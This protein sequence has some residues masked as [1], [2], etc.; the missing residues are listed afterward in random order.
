M[1]SYTLKSKSKP[2]TRQ[3][4]KRNM[5]SLV[6]FFGG[7]C[8]A[9]AYYSLMLT[10]CCLPAGAIIGLTESL[11]EIIRDARKYGCHDRGVVNDFRRWL[12]FLLVVIVWFAIMGASI[13]F[14]VIGPDWMDTHGYKPSPMFII[15]GFIFGLWLGGWLIQKLDKG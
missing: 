10:G 7:A 2:L 13:F 6:S 8:M 11:L 4:R 3:R 5:T 1:Y 15:V 12:R 14:L 9:I